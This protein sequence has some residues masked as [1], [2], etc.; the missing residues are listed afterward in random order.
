M[1]GVRTH[2][3]QLA[4]GSRYSA[5][6][7]LVPE[8]MYSTEDALAEGQRIYIITQSNLNTAL[9]QIELGAATER[10]IRDAVIAEWQITTHQD[11]ITFY[12]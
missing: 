7:H 4:I 9:D 11:Q 2:L 8:Q 12:D 3:I 10:E 5:K 1:N 6:E